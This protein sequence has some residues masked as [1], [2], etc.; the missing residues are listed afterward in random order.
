LATN[1][2]DMILLVGGS[3]HLPLLSEM[4]NEDVRFQGR[5]D[6]PGSPQWDV[7]HGAAILDAAPD[8]AYLLADQ[9]SLILADGSECCLVKPGA[10]PMSTP[11]PV[12]LSLVD[13]ANSANLIFRHG[14]EIKPLLYM[15]VPALGFDDEE[16]RLDYQLT[17]EWTFSAVGRSTSLGN[18]SRTED[19]TEE[20]KFRY[21]LPKS[22]K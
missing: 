9:I 20:L 12:F 5:F 1:D 7:A 22:V 17:S 15:T 3:S 21:L 2:V 16:L 14:I 8:G 18:R 4:L 13:N 19:E 6:K 11:K 10:Q